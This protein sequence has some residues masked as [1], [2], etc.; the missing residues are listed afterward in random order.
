MKR[1]VCFL[2]ISYTYTILLRYY[3]KET[4]KHVIW[5]LKSLIIIDHF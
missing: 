3:N 5:Y 4:N 2:K 1:L